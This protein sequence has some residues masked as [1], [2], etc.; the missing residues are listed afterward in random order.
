[1]S[2]KEDIVEEITSFEGIERVSKM[3]DQLSEGL[4]SLGVLRLIKLFPEQ[5]AML[6]THKSLCVE[7]ILTNMRFDKLLPGDTVSV[8]HL[9]RFIAES[10]EKGIYIYFCIHFT[11]VLVVCISLVLKELMMFV[12]GSYQASLFTVVFVDIE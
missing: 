10:T 12:T 5:F 7:D 6:F 1:M 3:L 4:K 9:K 11:V 2:N 8:A